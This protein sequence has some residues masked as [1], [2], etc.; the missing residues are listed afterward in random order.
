MP[1]SGNYVPSKGERIEQRR[2]GVR[3]LGRVWYSDGLQVLVKWDNGGQAVC[4]SAGTGSRSVV[5]PTR[6]R[7]KPQLIA[8]K[9]SF[10][11]TQIPGFSPS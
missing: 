1:G 6:I 10:G 8:K 7:Q 3:R 2:N 11:R 4:E 9:D 5:D